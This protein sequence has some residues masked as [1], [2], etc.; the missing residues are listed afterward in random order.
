[1]SVYRVF[2]SSVA[3]RAEPTGALLICALIVG[4]TLVSWTKLP[5][6]LVTGT[7]GRLYTS[8]ALEAIKYGNMFDTTNVN[9]FQG[10]FNQAIPFN[11]FFGPFVAFRYFPPETAR[12]MASLIALLAYVGGLLWFAR[13]IKVPWVFLPLTLLPP[14]LF[15]IYPFQYEF[16]YSVQFLISPGSYFALGLTTAIAALTARDTTSDRGIVFKFLAIAL[17]LLWLIVVEPLWAAVYLLMCAP[18]IGAAI[19][20]H[21]LR[22][23]IKHLIGYAVT[24]VFL[25]FAGPLEYVFL[26]VVAN[27]RTLMNIEFGRNDYGVIY[28][29]VLFKSEYGVAFY[30]FVFVLLLSGLF[31]ENRR[32]IALSLVALT[33]NVGFFFV[34]G[35]FLWFSERWALPMPIYFET[36]TIHFS[37]AIAVMVFGLR[38]DAVRSLPA[39]IWGWSDASFHRVSQFFILG[40]TAFAV[41]C[42]FISYMVMIVPE[43]RGNYIEDLSEVD[44]VTAYMEKYRE[45]LADRYGAGGIE[46]AGTI[47]TLRSLKFSGTQSEALVALTSNGIPTAA[48]YS[49]IISP[50]SHVLTSRLSSD[51]S[52]G[53]TS[54][55]GLTFI[56]FNANLSRMLGV[57]YILSG[58]ILNHADLKL[59]EP[60]L[61]F[62]DKK[63][64]YVYEL[65]ESGKPL[66][67]GVFR[68]EFS[69]GKT[70]ERLQARDFDVRDQVIL[71]EEVGHNLARAKSASLMWLNNELRVDID[72]DVPT[73]VVLP[74]QYSRCWGISSGNSAKI[75]RADGGL[76]ALSVQSGGVSTLRYR[77]SLWD[78]SCRR[79][80]MED[81]RSDLADVAFW[82]NK[83]TRGSG[84]NAFE[85]FMDTIRMSGWY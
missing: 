46:K 47:L 77:L 19:L 54:F 50:I 82:P 48:E 8:L 29:S 28:S 83:Y 65:S 21:P 55:N 75:L 80:D 73:V 15:T 44:A 20:I 63:K 61:I 2:T 32:I 5:A 24:A 34:L 79:R 10:A 64:M 37:T 78:P 38:F 43:R 72:S 13:S 74:V 57:K 68:V 31:T 51:P 49:Q 18:S 17:V 22:T 39:L 40:A 42:G 4:F 85:K 25:W 84:K 66:R 1:M 33:A 12:F 58:N 36:T 59:M 70:I 62:H 45:D 14:F 23:S 52:R 30:I 41:V 6:G 81:W 27:A 69:L 3:R 26:M 56:D 7:D 67:P 16:G 76:V 9:I 60:I 35:W 11:V 71:D 53:A